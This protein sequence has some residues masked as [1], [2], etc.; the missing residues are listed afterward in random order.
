MAGR[1]RR[2]A[3]ALVPGF[4]RVPGPL[5]HYRRIE[6]GEEL[7]RRQ[8]QQVA[9]GYRYEKT[10]KGRAR[11]RARVKIRSGWVDYIRR[12]LSDFRTMT[13]TAI[14]RELHRLG[15][16]PPSHGP[17]RKPTRGEAVRQ[18]A[19]MEF[20]GREPATYRQYYPAMLEG[21]ESE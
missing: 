1:R 5:R 18:E 8:Y 15:L 14:L 2:A 21:L 9:R 20:I 4:E 11:A 7:S 16:S 12:T 13:R 6:T 10:A 3:P 17:K 19:F